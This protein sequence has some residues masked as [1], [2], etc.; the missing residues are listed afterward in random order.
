M[1]R[2]DIVPLLTILTSA[3]A[4]AIIKL[5]ADGF[6]DARKARRQAIRDPVTEVEALRQSRLFLLDAVAAVRGEGA[7][8]GIPLAVLDMDQDPY[9]RWLNRPTA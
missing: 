8:R 9:V 5:I 6:A 4:G 1:I 7:E 3:G 2:L